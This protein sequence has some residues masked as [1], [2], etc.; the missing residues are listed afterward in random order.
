MMAF[1]LVVIG[2]TV[3]SDSGPG[4]VGS[5]GK[6][7]IAHA[8]GYSVDSEEGDIGEASTPRAAQFQINT[9]QSDP[10][11]ALD[12]TLAEMLPPSSP[13]PLVKRVVVVPPYVPMNSSRSQMSPR[14][15]NGRSGA[16]GKSA[17]KEVQHAPME[18]AESWIAGLVG[19]VVG[20]LLEELGELVRTIFRDLR[21]GLSL[22]SQAQPNL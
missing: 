10:L 18:G 22:L 15:A 4:G 3:A 19:E 6:V 5:D 11:K 9:V 8:R 13:F 20:E 1:P 16:K 2:I 12:D 17:R 7:P 21:H 14:K